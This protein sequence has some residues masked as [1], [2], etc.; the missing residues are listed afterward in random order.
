MK[1]HKCAR[2]SEA[3]ASHSHKMWTEVSSSAPHFL[4]VGLLLSPITYKFLLKVLCPARPITTLDCVLLKDNNRA[5]VARWRPDINSGACLCVLQGPPHNTKCLLSIQY[6]IFLLMF[7]LESPKKAQVQQTFEQNRLLRDCRRFLF[8]VPSMS[9]WEIMWNGRFWSKLP[10][11]RVQWRILVLRCWNQ[12]FT[13]HLF[14][15]ISEKVKFNG[16]L[17]YYN[18]QMRHPRCVLNN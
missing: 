1:E 12:W 10:R 17:C 13:A 14:H 9:I 7:C 4:Q 16:A 18:F 8:L 5:L 6:F 2:L 3:K 11:G 15:V